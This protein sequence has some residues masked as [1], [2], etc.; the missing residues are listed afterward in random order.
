MKLTVSNMFTDDDICRTDIPADAFGLLH[1]IAYSAESIFRNRAQA[2]LRIH[3]S[4]SLSLAA[5]ILGSA[6]SKRKAKTSAANG[7]LGG[8]PRKSPV[9]SKLQTTR[10]NHS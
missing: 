10:N 2:I 5:Q 4:Q 3:P 8:R 1:D 7:K 9:P 6:K